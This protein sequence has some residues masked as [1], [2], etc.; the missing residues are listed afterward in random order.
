MCY[1]A[2]MNIKDLIK[3]AGDQGKVLVIGDD[4][5]M[6]GV[7]L[8]Y[9]DYQKLSGQTQTAVAGPDPE[10]INREILEAQLKENIDASNKNLE[11]IASPLSAPTPIANILSE[12]ARDLFVSHPYGRQEA[13]LYDLREEVMDPNFNKPMPPQVDVDNEE[14][15]KPNFDDI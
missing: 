1:Y 8:S 14:E 13:P 2:V 5:E 7:F 15:I 9:A 10:K 12:R 6:K 3:L 4:G 11:V